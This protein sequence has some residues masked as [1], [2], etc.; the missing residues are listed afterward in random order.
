MEIK[1][2]GQGH[3]AMIWTGLEPVILRSQVYCLNHLTTTPSQ[4]IPV[5]SNSLLSYDSFFV[6]FLFT[7][8]GPDFDLCTQNNCPPGEICEAGIDHYYCY[9][10]DIVIRNCSSLITIRQFASEEITANWVE[11]TAYDYLG[12]VIQPSDSPAV[13]PGDTIALGNHEDF[14]YEY[15]YQGPSGLEIKRCHFRVIVGRGESTILTVFIKLEYAD[16]DGNESS[17]F[18]GVCRAKWGGDFKFSRNHE[19]SLWYHSYPHTAYQ[20]NQQLSVLVF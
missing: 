12:R 14:S 6:C 10:A 9:P 5:I 13:V 17:G 16:R 8:P 3:N 4:K 18:K 2:L 7:F 1:C 19:Y 15:R 11:P 20:S